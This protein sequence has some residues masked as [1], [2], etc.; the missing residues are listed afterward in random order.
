MIYL[1]IMLRQYANAC[2]LG[3]II[4][5]TC[6]ALGKFSLHQGFL[7]HKIRLSTSPTNIFKNV[8]NKLFLSILIIC[9]YIFIFILIFVHIDFYVGPLTHQKPMHY[10]VAS[11]FVV[12]VCIVY[13]AHTHINEST[14]LNWPHTVK[15]V[16]VDLLLWYSCYVIVGQNRSWL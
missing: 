11:R 15:I 4:R 10:F 13:G 7:T 9:L 16:Q 14:T 1:R 3:R 5:S 8:P 12:Y 6:I 2:T